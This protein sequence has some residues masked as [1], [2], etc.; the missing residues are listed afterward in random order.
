VKPVQ[1]VGE[2]DNWK[3][4][5][6]YESYMGRW[7][8]PLA[9]RFVAW[10][11]PVEEA[12]WLE[13]GCGTGALTSAICELANPGFLLACDPSA[14]FID[15][16]RKALPD[17][18][19]R[20]A[21]A[22]AEDVPDGADQLDYVVSGLV[23]NLLPDPGHALQSLARRLRRNGTLAAY[24]WDYADGIEFLRRFWDEAVA[25]DAGAGKLD[26]GRRFPVCRPAALEALAAGAGLSRVAVGALEVPTSF[27]DFDD[28]WRP[29][30]KGTGPAPAYVVALPPERRDRLRDRL[31]QRL[32]PAD[33]GSIRLKA[34]A[35]AVRGT[36]E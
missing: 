3:S 14:A 11:A 25:L 36:L 10:L 6:A 35:W 31:V 5:D 1:P 18:R 21:V 4:A 7:S 2:G 23:L 26:E 8:R 29:F 33:D 24:V 19:V 34:R 12:S 30:L 13:V 28:F 9:R 15:H 32:T 27:G 17:A 16:A 20:F 22:G